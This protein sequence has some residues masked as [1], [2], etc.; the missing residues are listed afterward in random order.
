MKRL[1]FA[2]ILLCVAAVQAATLG[3]S[4]DRT[5]IYLGES[6][7]ANVTLEGS[8]DDRNIPVFQ[9]ASPNE[10][11]YL[12]SRDNSQHSIVIINGKV[13]RNDFEGRVFVFRITPSSAGI[14]ETGTVTVKTPSGILSATG[15]RIEVTGVEKRD[16]ISASVSCGD[17]T[18]LVDSPFTITLSVTIRALPA[19]NAEFEPIMPGQPLHLEADYLNGAEVK[20]L[21]LPDL[22]AALNNLVSRRAG[23]EA[24]FTLNDYKQRGMSLDLFDFGGDPFAA[25]P[26]QFRLPPKRIQRDGTNYWEYAVSLDYTPT[27]EGDYTFGPVTVKGAVIVGARADGTAKMDEVFVVGPAV[28]V[29]VVPPPEEG[30]PDYFIGSVGKSM[31]ATASLDTSRCKVGDPLTLTLD[32]AGEISVSNLKP[33]ILSL[34]PGHSD[35]FRIYDDNIESENI[36]GGKRFKYRVRPLRAGTLEFPAVLVAYF[37]TVKG[38]YETVATDPMPLQVEETTR[39]ATSSVTDNSNSDGTVRDATGAALVPD[40]IVSSASDPPPRCLAK[41][42][43]ALAALLVGAP[44]F[45]VLVVALRALAGWFRR[46]R[47]HGTLGRRA[48]SNLRAFRQARARVSKDPTAAAAA[49]SSAARVA[50]AAKL[51]LD[52]VSLTVPEMR[53][54]LADHAVPSDTIDETCAAFEDLERLSYSHGSEDGDTARQRIDCLGSALEKA[55]AALRAVVAA[56]VLLG[57]ATRESQAAGLVPDTFEW[58][59][60]EQTMA[61]AVTEEDFLGAAAMY[62]AMVTN[63]AAS[64][65]LF[66]NLGTALLLSGKKLAAAEALVAAER[67]MGTSAE[68]ADNLRLALADEGSSGH[69]PVSRVFLCWHYGIPFATRVDLAVI[70]WLA[71][72]LAAAAVTLLGRSRR[73]R[74]FRALLRAVA[75]LS[76]II[77]VIYGASAAIT[78]LQN[79]HTDLPRTAAA[80]IAPTPTANFGKEA[81]Q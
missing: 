77:F 52:T 39:I 51:G 22:N 44:A 66:Y 67:R 48:A 20:G 18:V 26:I 9:K 55:F 24:A 10:V 42:P 62:Y 21:K 47:E 61:A 70:G 14:F 71:F 64:G 27:A 38:A 78:V 73:L 79:R 1:A 3:L 59:R 60:A 29:R 5:R 34:Q 12:G 33:P 19:P 13:T 68:V 17:Q 49:A 11:E 54:A 76:L 36:E 31:R 56:A 35:D 15:A 63:G 53:K 30:R 23:R 25:R 50:L 58:E 74:P 8:R 75:A 37:N 32:L 57:A 2:C 40:G 16:D 80:L 65:P 45:W 69:L 43:K 28:T 7:I 41:G 81:A 6:V 46:R 4:L 72:W